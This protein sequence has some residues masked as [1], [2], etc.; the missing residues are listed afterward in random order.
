MELFEDRILQRIGHL[1]M[2]VF[3]LLKVAHAV[4]FLMAHQHNKAETTVNPKQ[5]T[6]ILLGLS[7]NGQVADAVAP[8][9]NSLG[10]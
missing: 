9:G 2:C 6:S 8:T 3:V 4:D 1:L 7:K 5:L 10:V